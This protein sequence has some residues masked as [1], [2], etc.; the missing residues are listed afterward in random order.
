MSF[1]PL[2]TVQLTFWWLYGAHIYASWSIP[3]NDRETMATD[4]LISYNRKKKRSEAMIEMS[5]RWRVGW[6]ASRF[7][8]IRINRR[9]ANGRSTFPGH[10]HRVYV[11]YVLRCERCFKSIFCVVVKRLQ[12]SLSLP[13]SF[14][15]PFK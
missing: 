8:V 6:N 10:L 14:I 7:Y 3:V 15:T 4:Q 2:G 11:I 1:C 5:V 12:N 9:S 13:N